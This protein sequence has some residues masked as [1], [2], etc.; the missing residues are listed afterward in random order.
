MQKL[1]HGLCCYA[2]L[3]TA[4]VHAARMRK[5]M[6]GVRAYTAQP[7]E[8][9]YP[10]QEGGALDLGLHSSTAS[11]GNCMLLLSVIVSTL[12]AEDDSLP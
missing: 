4:C 3:H 5:E 7:H 9:R 12:C 11:L 6:P 1:L 10:A 2:V 8:K